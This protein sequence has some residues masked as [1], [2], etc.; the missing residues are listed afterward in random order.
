MRKIITD[1]Q[2]VTFYNEQAGDHYH[3]KSGARQ[4]AFEKHAKALEISQAEDPVIFDICF[5]LG[6]N[7]AAALDT[8]RGRPV[9]YC[10]ENDKEILQKILEIDADFQSYKVIKSFVR[11]FL[12]KGID[13]CKDNDAKLKMMFGDARE[14]IKEVE[15]KADFVFFD[16][17]SPSKVPEMWTREFFSDIWD[18]M[19]PGA[20]LSTY[21]CARFVR[22]N[23]KKA[24]FEIKDGP[25]LGRRSPSTI[26]IR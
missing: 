21:S 17:F 6:Y 24:G 15:E 26:A 7:S 10:F 19:K 3:T 2:S 16:P 18:R 1:D 13:V 12:E 11:Q 22:E 23:M 25:V 8:A 14:R 5:G 9:I 4:E 20:K